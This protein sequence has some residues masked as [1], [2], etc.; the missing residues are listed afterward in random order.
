MEK[1]GGIEQ[2]D[3]DNPQGFLLQAV[4]AFEHADVDDDLAVFIPRVGLE[5]HA[6]PAMTL[7]GALIVASGDGIGKG[8]ERGAFAAR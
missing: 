6:H 4:L 8:E 2:I 5:L 7:I 1:E 3:S